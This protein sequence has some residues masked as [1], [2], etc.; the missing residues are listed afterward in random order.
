MKAVCK[1]YKSQKG[2]F[3]SW[4]SNLHNRIDWEINPD[5]YGFWDIWG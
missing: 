2:Q 5:L 3:N 4:V 1:A